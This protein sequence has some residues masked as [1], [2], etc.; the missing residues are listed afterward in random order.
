MFK[1]IFFLSL[2]LI[3]HISFSQTVAFELPMV[4]TDDVSSLNLRIGMRDDATDD[5]DGAFDVAAP[6]PPPSGFMSAHIAD[7]SALGRIN[8]F[9]DFRETSEDTVRYFVTISPT[10]ANENPIIIKWDS[11]V[12]LAALGSFRMKNFYNDPGS[13]DLD[14]TTVDSVDTSL[15]PSLSN[16]SPVIE[17][18]VVTIEV[19]LGDDG[20]TAVE[21]EPSGLPNQF[22]LA[23]NYPNPFNPT[24][25]ILLNLPEAANVK[26]EILD[27]LGRQAMTLPVKSMAAGAHQAFPV[28]ASALASGIY[29]YRVTARM[30]RQTVVQ[31]GSMT[32]LR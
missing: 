24:T 13:F 19:V 12:D 32:L 18:L 31:T 21:D 10:N 15:H 29:F 26:V 25:T 4:V 6:P 27:A 22:T 30:H 2:F 7:T 11:S 3:P 28:D 5:F 16:N 23:G 14:M 9:T 20:P 8:L 1:Y 17:A